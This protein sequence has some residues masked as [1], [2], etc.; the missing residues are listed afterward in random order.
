MGVG[1]SGEG[2]AGGEPHR[3]KG[4]GVYAI[5]HPASGRVYVGSSGHIAKRW[6]EHRCALRA[7]KHHNAHLQRLWNKY[8][9]ESLAWEVLE[10]V[11]HLGLLLQREQFYIDGLGARG[12]PLRLNASPTAHSPRGTR[13]RP[14]VV[15]AMR[16]RVIAAYTNP[17]FR[18]V[19]QEGQRRRF[20]DQG[21][22]QAIKERNSSLYRVTTPEGDTLD[23]R[24]ITAFCRQNGLSVTRMSALARGESRKDNFR[25][26]RCELVTQS[27]SAAN[28]MKSVRPAPPEH[29]RGHTSQ[30][31]F[32]AKSPDGEM[33]EGLGLA[34]FCREKGLNE[35]A[36]RNVAAR[37]AAHHRGWIIRWEGDLRSE[38]DWTAVPRQR[39]L[40]RTYRLIDPE[41]REWTTDNLLT[42]ARQRALNAPTLVEVA[43]GRRRHHKGWQ[44]QYAD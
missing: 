23:V 4:A 43:R 14:E 36:A 1:V 6:R 41:G 31:A 32:R 5:R 18:R 10:T 34:K 2:E 40:I 39:G 25:G 15:E 21:E 26:W 35:A 29:G 28:R 37:R 13:H 33:F 7:G 38:D 19:H 44:V 27:V 11:D 22:R 12:S 17:D 16:L 30:K 20:Q 3:I 9:E 42:F 8:G 24:G